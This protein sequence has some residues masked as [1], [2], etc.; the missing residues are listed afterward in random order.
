[1][2]LEHRIAAARRVPLTKTEAPAVVF[3][4]TLLILATINGDAQGAQRFDSGATDVML[5]RSIAAKLLSTGS[6]THADYVTTKSYKLSKVHDWAMDNR[7]HVLT[8]A[9]CEVRG[10]SGGGGQPSIPPS[11]ARHQNL[12]TASSQ[13]RGK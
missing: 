10:G 4:S 11:R 3:G 9:Y 6:F 2:Y 12:S 5:R 8:L 13:C 1:M 7:R